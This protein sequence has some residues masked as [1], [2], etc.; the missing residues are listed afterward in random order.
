[1]ITW[2][3]EEIIYSDACLVFVVTGL[4]CA[5]VR[6]FH[7]CRPF[8]K[9]AYYFYPARWQVS[10]F[11]AAVVMELPYVFTPS[12]S[13]VWNYIR[14]FGILYYPMCLSSIFLRYFRQQRLDEWGDRLFVGVP[15]LML[16]VLMALAVAGSSLLAEGSAILMLAVV[17]C[18]V[19]LLGRMIRVTVWIKRRIDEYHLQNYSDE[20]DFPYKFA[21][22][23]LW[24]P[25]VWIAMQW[26][27]FLSD[28]RDVKAVTDVVM[29]VCLVVLLCAILHPQ[30]TLGPSKVQED[31]DRIEG[32]EE[33][34]IG[35]TMAAL[36][37][38]D[39]F[40][41]VGAGDHFNLNL[42]DARCGFMSD[43]GIRPHCATWIFA[44]DYMNKPI[45]AAMLLFLCA[46][47]SLRAGDALDD[48][49]QSYTQ[50]PGWYA[51]AEGGVP[52]GFST[53]SSFG[54]DRFRAGFD[55][56][57]FG[58]Y[59]FSPILSAEL[60]LK[61]GWT[62]MSARDCCA[63]SSSWLGN[64]GEQYYAPVL[65]VPSLHYSD[66][67]A[68]TSL[69]QYGAALNVNL[70]GFFRRTRDSRWSLEASPQLYAASTRTRINEITGGAVFRD[71]GTQ[72]HLGYGIAIQAA[73]R[74]TEPLRL[75]VYSGAAGYTG[76]RIDAMPV[77]HHK[78]DMLWESGVRLSVDLG[79]IFGGRTDSS[80]RATPEPAP[81]TEPEAMSVPDII[82]R[83]EEPSADTVTSR[84][85]SSAI[86]SDMGQDS[87]LA[88]DTTVVPAPQPRLLGEIHFGNE[89][90]TVPQSQYEALRTI[91]ELVKSNPDAQIDIIG[92]CDRYGTDAMNMRISQ[93]RADS[94]KAWLARRG[95]AKT[96]MQATGRGVDREQPD[97]TKARRVSIFIMES[98]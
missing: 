68:R 58:G 34:A 90:W 14:I 15:M 66:I 28:S 55:A 60:R 13:A 95:V 54:H 31:I 61:W 70:L 64:D 1:M 3:P 81:R 62:S 92:W 80:M 23:V 83:T 56:G 65:D 35:E 86:S 93:L 24:L 74:I 82:P 48:G 42:R 7:M 77:R 32:D 43:R 5:A 50:I 19:V 49:R 33:A 25:L 44:T 69:Q 12:S 59:R 9:E 71:A 30:R 76:D 10:F 38:N 27:V 47:A 53:F 94:V 63:Q 87:P 2:S 6:W 46:G 4:F 88:P 97:R 98:R 26:V 18:S 73:Y 29:S 89:E 22:K 8:D 96:R 85:D 79:A 67:Y 51:G 91:L 72:W 84:P 39:S 75:A 45:A 11:F 20:E 37:E 36:A 57:V 21:A 16:L 41:A 17:L 52:L 40:P 78:V